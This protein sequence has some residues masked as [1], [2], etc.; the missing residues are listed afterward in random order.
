[1][2]MASS[3]NFLAIPALFVIPR[4]D[5]LSRPIR[6]SRRAR[7]VTEPALGLM[8][9]PIFTRRLLKSAEARPAQERCARRDQSRWILFTGGNGGNRNAGTHF[10]V[11]RPLGRASV[12]FLRSLPF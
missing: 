4:K 5:G 3:A 10:D 9:M 8:M 6:L 1:M 12:G 2:R 7:L 11:R